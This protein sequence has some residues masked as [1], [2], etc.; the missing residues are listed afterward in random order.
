[1]LLETNQK[2]L[3]GPANV[4]QEHKTTRLFEQQ[5]KLVD[6]NQIFSNEK[7]I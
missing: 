4:S 2:L 6:S 5:S 3:Y 1:M 7:D